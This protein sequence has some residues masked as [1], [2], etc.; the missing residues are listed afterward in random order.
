MN[1]GFERVRRLVRRFRSDRRGIAAVEFAFIAPLLFV[2]YFVTMEVSQA[3]EANK[4]VGRAGSMVADLITQ[5]QTI[6]KSE[7]DA[8]MKITASIMQPYTRTTPKIIV[9]AIQVTDETTPKVKVAWSR[10][11]VKGVYSV[12]AAKDSITTIPAALKVKGTFLIRVEADLSYKPVITWTA[13]QKTSL[14]IA[15]AFDDIEMQKK[16]YLRPRM[17]TTIPC[18]DC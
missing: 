10:K 9:T 2:M 1:T 8:V 17:S 11:V 14:G 12:D 18:G 4:K 15:S 6:S 5:Q 16:Y 3:I 13:G 7:L